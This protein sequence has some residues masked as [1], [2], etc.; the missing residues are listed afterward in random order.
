MTWIH[1][2]HY[3]M[4]LNLSFLAAWAEIARAPQILYFLYIAPTF[5]TGTPNRVPV[6]NANIPASIVIQ[7]IFVIPTALVYDLANCLQDGVV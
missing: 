1:F 5:G 7:I 2:P 6:H 3:R 4:K